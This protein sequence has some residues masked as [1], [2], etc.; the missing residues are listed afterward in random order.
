[1]YNIASDLKKHRL[2]NDYLKVKEI[3]A[4]HQFVCWVVGGAVRDF[5]I[6]RE[7]HEF[8]LV[9]DATTEVLKILFPKAVLVGESFGV[10]KLPVGQGEFFDLSTFRQE[11]DYADGRRPSQVTAATPYL[12]SERRDFTINALYWDDVRNVVVD[13][14]GGLSDLSQRLLVCVGDPEIR[15][16]EDYLRIMRLVRFSA[17][18][19]FVVEAKT[20]AS[21]LKN[22]DKIKKVSGERV[23]SELKKIKTSEAWRFALKQDLFRELLEEIF[24]SN[25]IDLTWL[26]TTNLEKVLSEKIIYLVIYLIN[27]KHDFSS[28]L[29]S[30]LKLSNKELVIYTSIYFLM[31]QQEH[32]TLGQLAFELEKS[33]VLR[34]QLL[35][36]VQAGQVS[37]KILDDV[38]NILNLHPVPFVNAQD[39]LDLIPKNFISE[40]LR[41]LRVGQLDG[42]YKTKGEVVVHLKKKYADMSEKP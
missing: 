21:A 30:R 8:D 36:L 6:G 39:L 25:E 37:K 31:K 38:Q 42:D 22:K 20:A 41:L 4:S 23:W 14:R 29:K 7:V 11:S 34:E 3:L 26:A 18:L 24:E 40:E 15:F 35:M 12:D 13:Y 16:N 1:V 19:A 2:Y 5:C 32:F 27:T 17:Q 9:T 10:L 33:E 28:L